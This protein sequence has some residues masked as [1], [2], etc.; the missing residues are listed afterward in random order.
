M[1]PKYIVIH[2]HANSI[3]KHGITY[4]PIEWLNKLGFSYHRLYYDTGETKS[5]RKLT[6]IAHHAGVSKWGN[7]TNL[8]KCSIGLC[9]ILRDAYDWET[10]LKENDNIEAFSNEMYIK[11]AND[12]ANIAQ[13]FDI[14]PSI[15]TILEHNEVSGDDVRGKGKGKIDPGNSFDKIRLLGMIQAKLLEQ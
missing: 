9:I 8:N 3:T 7:D 10:F 11:L 13:M 4:T 12:C 2:T 5:M 14:E 15:Y 6:E 1:K